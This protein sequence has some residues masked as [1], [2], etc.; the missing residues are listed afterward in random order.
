M[1]LRSN[2]PFKF[3]MT[4]AE[5]IL[6][7]VYLLVHAVALPLFLPRLCVLVFGNGITTAEMN[8][9]MYAVSFLVVLI[10]MFRFLRA[11]FADLFDDIVRSLQGMV[12]GY[13]FYYVMMLA[14]S[15]LIL[16][17]QSG[18]ANPNTDAIMQET[19]LN[20][21]V[22]IVVAVLF[23]PIVEEAL[24]RG[25]VFGTIRLKSRLAAYIVS[26]ALFAIYHLWQYFVVDGFSWTLA[27]YL[28]QY[29]PPS[30]A[31]AW[32]YERS[33][34]IWAP[35]VIHALINLISITVSLNL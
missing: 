29:I 14:V 25:A 13:A 3:P 10:G 32:S 33:G 16:L 24:F 28:L 27:I 17:V 19:R 11:S 22:M 12:L 26:A 18:I 2:R 5:R 15:L 20:K 7:C 9:V 35:I 1:E 23:A 30:I 31:L 8:L 34:S 4:K 6:G 21:N